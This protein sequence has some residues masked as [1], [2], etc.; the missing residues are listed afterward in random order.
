MR[1]ID[2]RKGEP[3]KIACDYGRFKTY[4]QDTLRYRD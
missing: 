4:L 3:E 1:G 2:K